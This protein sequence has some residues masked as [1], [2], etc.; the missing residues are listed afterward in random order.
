MMTHLGRIL[1]L[2]MNRKSKAVVSREINETIGNEAISKLIEAFDCKFHSI[3]KIN[4]AI[5]MH[6]LCFFAFRREH[7][8]IYRYITSI[9]A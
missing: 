6:C 2:T 4:S 7:A 8:G 5:L 9:E 3:K 1:S